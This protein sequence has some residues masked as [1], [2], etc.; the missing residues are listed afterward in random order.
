M[1]SMNQPLATRL[2][3]FGLACFALIS[4]VA[5]SPGV[6]AAAGPD[7]PPPADSLSSLGFIRHQLHYDHKYPFINYEDNYFEWKQY[8][9]IQPLVQKLQ[10]TDSQRV[11]ILHIGDSHVQADIYPGLVRNRLQ[12]IF[13]K[14]GR[15]F[16]FPYATANTHAAYDYHTHDWGRWTYARNTQ[17]HPRL[18][19]GVTGVTART[20]DPQAGFRIRFNQRYHFKAGNRRLRIFC[21][22]DSAAFDLELRVNGAKEPLIVGACRDSS[23]DYIDL[24]LA[25]VKEVNRLD[26]RMHRSGPGQ[27]FFQLYGISLERPDS[28]GLLY[29]SVGINGADFESILRQ[30]KMNRHLK[31]LRPDAIIFDVSGNEYFSGLDR[32]SFTHR[33]RKI[34]SN[35]RETL[36]EAAVIVS[37][38]QDIHRH[39][40][41][42]LPYTGDAAE[43]ARQVAFET[44]CAFYNYYHVAGEDHSMRKWYAHGMAKHDRI[45]L[46]YE[47]YANKAGLLSNALL[48]TYYETLRG[49]TASPFPS[50]RLPIP[51]FDEVVKA[52]DY[53]PRTE[54]GSGNKV[55]YTVQRGDVLGT[56]AERYH[57]RVS[58]LRRWNGLRG[59]MIRAGQKLVVYTKHAPQAKTAAHH[60]Q[61]TGQ[62]SGA[63]V[64][65]QGDSLWAIAQ[66][67]GTSVE[68]LCR[69][70]GLSRSATLDIGQR[71]KLP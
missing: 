69:L 36:P 1:T 41:R 16:V 42:P 32:A 58:D 65:R 63:H 45:H 14:G 3:R 8:A 46:T 68:A 62:A 7:D 23:N 66:A 26:V 6:P 11:S 18:P 55:V 10:R 56:I 15:G 52:K 28:S 24:Q 13:G 33:L 61:A 25:D 54:A 44:G 60:V 35:L 31:A 20:E 59:S 57:V 70:N 51:V 17:R 34:L 67:Y 27:T 22:C 37:C 5:L 30:N 21:E 38:S 48:T 2:A 43:L 47:G 53:S 39:R 29:H 4:L 9:A 50:S 71:L 12:T 49:D 19:L 64:V 40:Y